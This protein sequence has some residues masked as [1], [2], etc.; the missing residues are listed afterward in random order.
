MQARQSRLFRWQFLTILL[1]LLGYSGYYLC[2]S[3]FSVALPM[4]ADELA[5]RGF[6][7]EIAPLGKL[8]EVTAVRSQDT[9]L[10]LVIVTLIQSVP[11]TL[12]LLF[13]LLYFGRPY[14]DEGVATAPPLPLCS[15]VSSITA[16]CSN[17]VHGVGARKQTCLL[18]RRRSKTT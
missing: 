1:M 6:S 7:S 13:T 4:I 12:G 5:R 14:K 18:R 2:R 17:V 3:N 15:I 16:M 9:T 11:F 10:R 8:N